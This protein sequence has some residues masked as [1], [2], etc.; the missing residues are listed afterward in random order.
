MIPVSLQPEPP[1]FES[2]VRTPGSSFLATHS[3]NSSKDLKGHEYWRKCL[4]E[5]H[6]SYNRICAYHAHWISR[7]GCS[8]DHYIP[9]SDNINLAYEWKNYRLSGTYLNTLKHRHRDVLDPFEIDDNTFLIDFTTLKVIPSPELSVSLSTQVESTIKRLKLNE[10]ILIELRYEWLRP[11]CNNECTFTFLKG[12]APFTAYEI[13]RQ[14]LGID[15]LQ[16][17]FRIPGN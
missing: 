6:N 15:T 3:P 8:V 9:L 16:K 14:S 17:L 7:M 2:N 5:L 1:N 10:T 12:K 11:Y 4:T 13:E